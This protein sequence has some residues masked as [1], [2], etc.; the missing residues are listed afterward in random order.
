MTDTELKTLLEVAEKSG[1]ASIDA[2]ADVM[3][4]PHSADATTRLCANVQ[5]ENLTT[6]IAAFDPVTRGRTGARSAAT[7]GNRSRTRQGQ[8][9]EVVSATRKEV[10]TM[11][12]DSPQAQ[13]ELSR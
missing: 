4:Y 6:F 11:K 12:D 9:S 10:A 7:S 5:L 13:Q 2:I 1:S 8:R 3:R